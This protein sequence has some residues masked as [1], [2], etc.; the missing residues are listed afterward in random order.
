MHCRLCLQTVWCWHVLGWCFSSQMSLGCIKWT[1]GWPGQGKNCVIKKPGGISQP[2]LPHG[3]K[4]RPLLTCYSLYPGKSQLLTCKAES[5]T[6]KNGKTEPSTH[7]LRLSCYYMTL[8]CSCSRESQLSC[9]QKSSINGCVWI[10]NPGCKY[11]V[12]LP[13]LLENCPLKT[14]ILECCGWD[15]PRGARAAEAIVDQ[16]PLASSWPQTPQGARM[17]Q[18]RIQIELLTHIASWAKLMASF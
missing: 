14:F 4:Q 3:S 13:L 10:P 6:T 16:Q 17:S 12:W 1:K 18:G 8:H 9:N 2:L 11:L 5:S 7:A 15:T